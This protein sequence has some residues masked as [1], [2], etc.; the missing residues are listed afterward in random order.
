MGLNLDKV[1]YEGSVCI[2]KELDID[3]HTATINVAGAILVVDISEVVFVTPPP[4]KE[5]SIQEDELRLL[6]ESVSLQRISLGICPDCSG[7]LS[8]N[9]NNRKIGCRSCD[10][11]FYGNLDLNRW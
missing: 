5:Q 8:K 11:V 10:Y 9:S 3:K 1:I 2:L 4:Q 6:K 7:I